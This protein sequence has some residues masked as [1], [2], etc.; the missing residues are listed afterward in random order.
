MNAENSKTKDIEL[1]Q[2]DDGT[3]SFN[4]NVFEETVWLTQKQMAKLSKMP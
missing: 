2:S 3:I 1:F 4:V